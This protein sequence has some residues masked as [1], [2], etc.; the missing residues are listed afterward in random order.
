MSHDGSGGAPRGFRLFIA[1]FHCVR[2]YF[3]RGVLRRAFIFSRLRGGKRS[4]NSSGSSG[5]LPINSGRQPSH[6]T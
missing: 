5:R 1:W 3:A 2:D 4:E 6:V